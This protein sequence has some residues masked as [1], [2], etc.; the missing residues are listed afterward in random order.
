MRRLFSSISLACST[1]RMCAKQGEVLSMTVGLDDASPIEGAVEV[2]CS[3]NPSQAISAKIV[4]SVAAGKTPG[5]IADLL[6]RACHMHSPQIPAFRVLRNVTMISVLCPL[7]VGALLCNP[8]SALGASVDVLDQMD[9]NDQGGDFAFENL[10]AEQ[11][12]ETADRCLRESR[13]SSRTKM[14][15]LYIIGRN[16]AAGLLNTMVEVYPESGAEIKGSILAA[17]TNFTGDARARR[18]FEMGVKDSAPNA[19]ATAAANYFLIHSTESKAAI[20]TLLKD[21]EPMVVGA[22]AVALTK[23]GDVSACQAVRPLQDSSKPAIRKAA[24]EAMSLC[25]TR[26]DISFLR[27]VYEDKKQRLFVRAAA[28]QSIWAISLRTTETRDKKLEYL[29]ML[30]GDSEREVGRQWAAHRL[31]DLSDGRDDAWAV[32]KRVANTPGHPGREQA[33][34]ALRR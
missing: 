3:G 4:H 2:S 34:R 7:F 15:C 9:K 21:P 13:R 6:K 33:Q 30:L 14:Y 29:S 23:I 16:K 12:K 17:A 27:E 31:R 5:I 18:I 28:D 11:F 26:D 10:P 1:M 24:L 22:A 20:Q 19:R 8:A 32:L 25:G